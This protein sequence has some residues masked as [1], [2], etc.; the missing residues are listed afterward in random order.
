MLCHWPGTNLKA[1]R[2]KETPAQGC[3]RGSGGRE[4]DRR[5]VV[6]RGP[7]TPTATL[8]SRKVGMP[9]APVGGAAGPADLLSVAL[10]PPHALG[11]A[12]PC[13]CTA[14]RSHA[15]KGLG[16]TP[17]APHPNNKQQP[18]APCTRLRHRCTRS[19]SP[20]WSPS[21]SRTPGYPGAHIGS[22]PPPRSCATSRAPTSSRPGRRRR[23]TTGTLRPA[24]AACRLRACVC[25]V[26]PEI[27]ARL[28]CLFEAGA[29]LM[30][31]GLAQ[32]SLL[33]GTHVG[34]GCCH[35]LS[36]APG[37]S[38]CLDPTSSTASGHL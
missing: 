6:G 7:E 4:P 35:D 19:W 33:S 17:I 21:K 27:G 15:P 8:D 9:A 13:A 25:W 20:P 37:C 11:I 1:P 5:G 26:G 16:P 14:D 36:T 32:G 29:G 22:P 38:A 2:W 31:A 30:C 28:E 10:V 23:R 3:A 34:R 24:R 12:L 18:P